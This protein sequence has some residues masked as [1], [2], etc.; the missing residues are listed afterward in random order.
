MQLS[1]L[2]VAAFLIVQGSAVDPGEIEECMSMGLPRS[3][4]VIDGMSVVIVDH[5]AW[6]DWPAWSEIMQNFFTEDMVYDSNW[7][8]NG[9][10]SNSTG[11]R[12]WFLAE[13]I[14]FNLAFDNTSFHT[15]IYTGEETTASLIAYGKARWIGD[16]GT[17]PGSLAMGQEV[18]IWDLDFYKLDEDGTRIFYNW[19]L[20]DFVDLARQLGYQMLPKSR[21]PEGMF[22]PPRAMDGLSAPV[23]RL[24]NPE[25]TIISKSIVTELLEWDFVGDEGSSQLWTEDLVWYGSAGFGMASGRAQYEDDF[26]TP[27]KAGVSERYLEVDVV[28]CEGSY[29]GAHGYLYGNH[30]GLWLGEQPTFLPFRL[31]FGIHWRVEVATRQVPEAWAMFDLPAAFHDI[32]I[33]LFERVNEQYLV[34]VP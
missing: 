15:I 21:L 23:S 3:K 4:C 7:T 27:L 6:D 20:I 12:E 10:F 33:D 29:C 34:K 14:P 2:I 19:C 25:D 8:P 32:G 26:L 17:L 30:T 5:V 16:L 11:L 24:V 1:A 22:Y 31:R 28:S 13:H 18:T 9:D